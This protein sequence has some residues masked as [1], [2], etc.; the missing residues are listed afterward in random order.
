MELSWLDER[1]TDAIVKFWTVRNGGK[2]VLGGKTL[3]AFVHIIEHVVRESGLANAKAYIGRNTSQLPGFFRP[4]KSWDVVVV[5]DGKLIAAIEFK[6]QVGSIGNNFNNR[7]EEV[8]GSSL[9]LRTAIEESAFGEDA[10]IFTGYIIVVE[11]SAAS[12]ATPNINMSFFPVMP[13]FLLD[14]SVRDVSYT[15]RKDG[16]HPRTKGIS[17]IDRYDLMCKR[18][19]MKGLYTATALIASPNEPKTSG[20]YS[21]VSASTS[22][23][24]FMLKLSKHCEVV[25]SINIQNSEA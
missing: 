15:R 3:N 5:D 13:G 7:T 19:M 12:R 2:G 23:Q 22:I 1:V 21:N 11:D 18:L 24:T 8:L 4:H 17:Y 14:E 10:N 20:T 6:S 25:Q 16:T 9:D